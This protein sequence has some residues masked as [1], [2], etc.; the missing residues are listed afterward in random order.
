M[1]IIHYSV[2]YSVGYNIVLNNNALEAG[3]KCLSDI[4]QT[5]PNAL[6]FVQSIM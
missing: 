5:Q 1:Y 2:G 6:G 3:K 4:R